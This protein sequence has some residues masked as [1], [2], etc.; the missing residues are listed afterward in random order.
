MTID[1]SLFPHLSSRTIMS[2]STKPLTIAITGAAG[3]VGAEVALQ[4]IQAGHSVIAL[5]IPVEGKI[6]AQERYQYIQ[7][8]A[9]DYDAFK[10]AV[11]ECDALVHLAAVF[12]THDGQGGILGKEVQE[13]VSDEILS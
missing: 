13:H 1:I 4:A 12:N 3:H 11:K 7:L 8:D 5:D 9:S 10:S 2:T 6:P